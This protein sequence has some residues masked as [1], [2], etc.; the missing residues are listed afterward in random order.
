[1]MCFAAYK[2]ISE[3]SR[4]QE[5]D[6]TVANVYLN[7]SAVNIETLYLMYQITSIDTCIDTICHHL[8]SIRWISFRS[9]EVAIL[10]C[11]VSRCDDT[12][13][14]DLLTLELMLYNTILLYGL[15]CFIFL[16]VDYEVTETEER[17]SNDTRSLVCSSGNWNSDRINYLPYAR[18]YEM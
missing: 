6:D 7:T 13:D 17:T 10:K 12:P 14:Y 9:S 3:Y 1:M 5:I 15:N 4:I 16:I 8:S 18:S 11:R 2:S